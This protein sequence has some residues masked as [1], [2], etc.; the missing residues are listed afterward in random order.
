MN[1][2]GNSITCDFDY[3]IVCLLILNDDNYTRSDTLTSILTKKKHN[4]NNLQTNNDRCL[5]RNYT[6]G[7]KFLTV[8]KQK[9]VKIKK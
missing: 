7:M 4:F 5:G 6:F 8:D 9:K 2:D 3:N 1:Y